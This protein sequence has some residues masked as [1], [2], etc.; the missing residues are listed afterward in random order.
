M[1]CMAGVW[2]GAHDR[3][4]PCGGHDHPPWNPGDCRASALGGWPYPAPQRL[5]F[6]PATAIATGDLDWW[7]LLGDGAIKC[8]G[9][10]S[11]G[12][13]GNGT[14]LNSTVPLTVTGY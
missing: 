11:N 3:E 10:N 8:W 1:T 9:N 2:F 6:R 4:G 12:P 7:A 13:L 14:T 5:L